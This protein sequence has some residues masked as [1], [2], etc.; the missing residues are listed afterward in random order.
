MI[1]AITRE[2]SPRL[3]S[4][5]LTHVVREK[6]DIKAA[7]E[8]HLKYEECLSSLGCRIERLP[9]TPELADSVFVEDTAI[10]LDEAAVI[11]R[12]G[13]ASR[14]AEAVSVKKALSSYRDLFC[15]KS[16]GTLDG[17]D[18]LR[19]GKHLFVGKSSRSNEGGILQLRSFLSPFGYRVIDIDITDCLHLK[20]AVCQVAMNTLLINPAWVDKRAFTGMEFIEID[21]SEPF[22]ANALLLDETVIYPQAYMET[23][24]K[25]EENG[26]KVKS[27][28]VSELAKAEGGVTCCSLLFDA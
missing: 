11:T 6:I 17:G 16:P 13:T 18:V 26:I 28:D 3:A 1:I 10:V 20:S 23:R 24:N 4:C 19:V 5:E 7:R 22:G 27:V 21:P 15:I 14:Q 25:L 12:P 9:E 2:L 8:Q